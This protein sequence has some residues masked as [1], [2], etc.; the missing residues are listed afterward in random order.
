MLAPPRTRVPVLT[1]EQAV[2]VAREIAA[3]LAEVSAERD[4]DRILPAVEVER[5]SASGLLA[6]TVPTTYGGAGLSVETLTEVFRILA[7]GDKKGMWQ[8]S[9]F[10][11]LV[12]YNDGFRTGLV[13]T[14]EQVAERLIALEAAGLDLVLLQFSP[15]LEEMERF[16]DEVIPLVNGRAVVAA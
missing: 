13:G 16:A 1:A 9:D 3:D 14:P 12:Q 10:R 5:L 2:E 6:V 4:R 7:T 15:Q 11:D 8:D